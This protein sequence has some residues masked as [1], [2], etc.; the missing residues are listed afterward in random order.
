MLFL[1]SLMLALLPL[2]AAPVLIHFLNL[3]RHKKVPW[4]ATRFLVDVDSKSTRKLK[5]LRW[6]LL[7]L[8]VFILVFLV[9]A[10]SRPLFRG[11]LERWDWGAPKNTLVL[12]DR[13]ASMA[14]RSPDGTSPRDQALAALKELSATRG[15]R[16]FLL[17]SFSGKVETVRSPELLPESPAL[18][19]SDGA[20]EMPALF[21]TAADFVLTQNPGPCEL[22]ILSDLAA[23]DWKPESKLWEKTAA[24]L[25]PVKRDVQIRVLDCSTPRTASRALAVERAAPAPGGKAPA[26][27]F[28]LRLSNHGAA[29]P[30][31]LNLVLNLNGAAQLQT[32]LDSKGEGTELFRRRVEIPAGDGVVWGC[33]GLEGQD[34]NRTYFAF[35]PKAGNKAAVVADPA[36]KAAALAVLALS[37]GGKGAGVERWD[38]ATAAEKP[39]EDFAAALVLGPV[40]TAL[41]R[42]ADAFAAHGGQVAFFPSP[43]TPATDLGKEVAVSSWDHSE[44]VF[45]DAPGNLT[46][47]IGQVHCRKVAEAKLP[48]DDYATLADGKPFLSREAKGTGTVYRCAAALSGKWTDF[49]ERPAFV[50]MARRLVEDG[51]SRL[52]AT[53]SELCG[54]WSPPGAASWDTLVSGRQGTGDFSAAGVYK[55]KNRYLALNVPEAEAA[56]RKVDVQR[57]GDLFGGL[58]WSL[59]GGARTSGNEVWPLFALLALLCFM[60]ESA[61]TLALS[62]PPKEAKCKS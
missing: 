39:W 59:A 57:L 17:D 28:I 4:A 47:P 16:V 1:N 60:G 54:Q 52:G 43:D 25:A 19:P 11:W 24:A 35:D 32:P 53:R 13:S 20:A 3:L 58:S 23:N 14:A 62:G 51:S 41:A 8:R 38:T 29:A 9:L 2:A 6:L 22:L 40:D 7:L 27:D 37:P 34:A 26:L 61:L 55:L 33:W 48:G 18:R 12:L 31:K 30:G 5:M 10:L 56:L 36:D 49:P 50:L 45:R 42:R 46:L 15:G 21:A 44:G